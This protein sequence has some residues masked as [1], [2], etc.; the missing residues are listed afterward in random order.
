MLIAITIAVTLSALFVF[1]GKV[2]MLKR[3]KKLTSLKTTVIA[4]V[5]LVLLGLILGGYTLLNLWLNQRSAAKPTTH[6]LHSNNQINDVP[7]ISGRP[8]R[9]RISS[10]GIDL[11]VVPGYYYK[12]SNSWTLTLNDAQWGVMTAPANN[13]Q[14]DTFIYAHYRQGVFLTLPR[15][16]PGAKAVVY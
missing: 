4:G 5:I 9:L 13:Q 8:V 11:K 2:I 10:V 6:A 1:L 12:Q 3:Y 7:L 14:G 15:I 16:K